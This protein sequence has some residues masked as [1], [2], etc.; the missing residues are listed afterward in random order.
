MSPH[1]FADN[2]QMKLNRLKEVLPKELAETA[3]NY[4]VMAFDKQG[5]NNT[6]WRP[7]KDKNTWPIL[8]KSGAL[9][10]SVENSIQTATWDEIRLTSDS[11][12]GGYHNE[13]TD[14]L[15]QRQFM[16]E[17]PELDALLNEVVLKTIK[18]IFE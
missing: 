12:Y 6:P 13:G 8:V 3:K 10:R 2:L 9:K 17:S 14:R 16:G 1:E 15:P 5:W 4:F 18:D 7:R 11:E